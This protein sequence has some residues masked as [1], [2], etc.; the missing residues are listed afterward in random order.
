MA[1][2]VT[3][4]APD[5]PGKSPGTTRETTRNNRSA[6]SGPRVPDQPT[7]ADMTTSTVNPS[8]GVARH[9]PVRATI[10]VTS[11]GPLAI[12]A[13]RGLL[14][15]DTV[16]DAAIVVEKVAAHPAA[17]AAV[18]WLSY[19]AL[20]TLPL[21]LLVV[22]GVAVRFRPLLGS[23]AAVVAWVGFTGLTFLI[24][25]D[26]VTQAGIDAGLP[27]ATTAALADALNGSPVAVTATGLFVAGH[28]LGTS[29]LGLALWQAIPRWAALALIISQPL[30]FVFAVIV[31]N[32]PLDALCWVLTAIGFTAAAVRATSRGTRDASSS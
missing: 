27:T 21:G 22:S 23:I 2:S 31:P 14:P 11:I 17:E 15:Y 7:V 32:H 25:P 28:I 19:V 26:Q 6:R 30:H 16:D 4:R 24:T 20:L 9:L 5:C 3:D 18:L 8:A 10:L 1:D 13:L 29:L 12:A